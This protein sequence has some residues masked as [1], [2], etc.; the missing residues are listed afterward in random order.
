MDAP[1]IVLESPG[2]AFFSVH[3]YEGVVEPEALLARSLAAM[4]EDYPELE[5]S[6]WERPGGA[7]RELDFY[8]LDLVI[9]SRIWVIPS[10]DGCLLVQMQAESREFDRQEAVFEAM[11]HSLEQSLEDDDATG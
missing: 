3:R 9:T 11:L 2:G 4:R 6:S 8:C 5:E 1:G 7:G 10:D